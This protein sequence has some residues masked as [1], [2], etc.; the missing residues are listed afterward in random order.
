M[1]KFSDKVLLKSLIVG[2]LVPLSIC[3]LRVNH[4]A[5]NEFLGILF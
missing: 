5:L 2:M 4:G 1:W 3:V